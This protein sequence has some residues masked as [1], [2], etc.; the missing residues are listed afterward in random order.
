MNE[1]KLKPGDPGYW[2]ERSKKGQKYITKPKAIP[3]PETLWE[4]AC[5]YFERTDN[6]PLH[7]K[8]FIRGGD[9]AGK[10]V[11]I[12]AARPYTWSAFEDYLFEE[13]VIMYLDDYRYDRG[14]KYSEF[15]E[16]VE[17]IG[18]VMYANK[19]EGASVGLFN[20][21]II[22]R[23]LGLVEKVQTQNQNID[24]AFDYSGLSDAAL[25]EIAAIRFQADALPPAAKK[26]TSS[27]KP[28]EEAKHTDVDTDLPEGYEND[29]LM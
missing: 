7:K 8:D 19:F 26:L 24:I 18:R 10:E 21:S 6:A 4:L 9:N 16:V 22:A 27:D 12:K 20:P 5:L 11:N 28:I 17:L 29:E 14:G 25:E 3:N 15:K 23:E 2:K 13:G 1:I